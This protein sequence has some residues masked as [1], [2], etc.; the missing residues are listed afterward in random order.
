MCRIELGKFVTTG[1]GSRGELDE[2]GGKDVAKVLFVNVP[3]VEI[4]IRHRGPP[5]IAQRHDILNN[6]GTETVVSTSQGRKE[7]KKC[8]PNNTFS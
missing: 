3:E 1:I 2:E 6:R 4:E 8:E 7:S 5:S